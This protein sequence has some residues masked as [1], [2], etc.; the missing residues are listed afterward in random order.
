MTTSVR[1]ETALVAV[2]C[3]AAA[4]GAWAQTTPPKPLPATFAAIQVGRVNNE[5]GV[6]GYVTSETWVDGVNKRL[7]ALN[8]QQNS[9]G[10]NAR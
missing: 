3:V 1:R 8:Q 7:L 9:P 6:E 2:L 4:A 10:V 5:P